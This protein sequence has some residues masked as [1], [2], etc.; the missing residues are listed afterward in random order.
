MLRRQFARARVAQFDLYG[1]VND[2]K[3]VVKLA[4]EPGVAI[5]NIV[6]KDVGT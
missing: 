2:P 5:A 1:R 3:L 6:P 4:I